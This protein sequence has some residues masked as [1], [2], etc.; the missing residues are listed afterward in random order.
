M[1]NEEIIIRRDLLSRLSEVRGKFG[2]YIYRNSKILTEASAEAVRIRDDAIRKYGKDDSI[3]PDSE[4]WDKYLAEVTPVMQIEQDV[5]L[6][7]MPRAEFDELAK[8]AGLSAVELSILDATIV[9][10]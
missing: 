1:T 10:E 9:E 7:R 3:S 4:N 2:W 6:V 5:A 8:D